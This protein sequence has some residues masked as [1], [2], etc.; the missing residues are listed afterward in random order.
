M[1]FG[2]D[3]Q[4]AL[5]GGGVVTAKAGSVTEVPLSGVPAGPYTVAAS[6]DVSFTAAARLTLG[7]TAVNGSTHVCTPV[8]L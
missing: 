3:G 8:P 4:K 2:R 7:L 1:L 5:P 6:S